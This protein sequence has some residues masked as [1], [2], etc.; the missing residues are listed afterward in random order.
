MSEPPAIQK[1]PSNTFQ[2]KGSFRIKIDNKIVNTT[3]NL[4]IGATLE[5][6]P[7]CNALK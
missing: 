4:S 7:I 1:P 5:A 6:S 3:L 2:L